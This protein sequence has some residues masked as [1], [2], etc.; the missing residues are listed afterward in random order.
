MVTRLV[1]CSRC[2]SDAGPSDDHVAEPPEPRRVRQSTDSATS[3]DSG[4]GNDGQDTSEGS[5]EAPV[6]SWMVEECI[7]AASEV[8]SSAKPLDLPASLTI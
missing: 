6:Y 3:G 5:P 7:L 1:P 2:L 4:V 8:M